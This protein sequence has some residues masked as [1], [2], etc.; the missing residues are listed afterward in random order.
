MVRYTADGFWEDYKGYQASLGT[1]PTCSNT[2]SGIVNAGSARI[3]GLES[4]VEA[5]LG[6]IGKLNVSV[7]Y[8]QAYFT[9]FQGTL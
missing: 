8:L 6:P 2:V 3:Y 7:N 9:Q 5:L 1:C 4:S